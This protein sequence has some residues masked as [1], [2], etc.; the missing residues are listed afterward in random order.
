MVRG[1]NTGPRGWEIEDCI[2]NSHIT[3]DLVCF[4]LYSIVDTNIKFWT[5]IYNLYTN[6]FCSCT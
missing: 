5:S 1:L 4:G 6:T 3:L 2:S